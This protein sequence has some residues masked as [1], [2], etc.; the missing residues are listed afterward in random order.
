[1]SII[2]RPKAI[3]FDFDGTIADTMRDNFSAWEQAFKPYGVQVPESEYYA[4]EGYRPQDITEHFSKKF[5]VPASETQKIMDAKAAHFKKNHV[6]RVYPEI[7][8]LMKW[9]QQQGIKIGIVSG[10]TLERIRDILGEERIAGCS[11]IIHADN[12]HGS[13]KPAPDH[14][15]HAARE[16]GINPE[17]CLVIENAPFGIEAAKAAGMSCIGID[18]TLS[19][20]VL[21][22]LPRPADR[23]LGIGD[24]LGFLN[25][26]LP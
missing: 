8:A 10:A 24:I 22:A 1:M 15:L 14:F 19:R 17:D 4:L 23:I 5:S 3:L 13:P 25:R 6:P 16:L 21:R 18:T 7:V 12:S 2:K 11:V 26:L 9:A 20:D